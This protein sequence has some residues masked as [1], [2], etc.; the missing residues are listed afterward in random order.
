MFPYLL[1]FFGLTLN[2]R[3]HLFSQ[4]HEIVFHGGGGYDWDTIYNMPLWLRKFTFE[5][6]KEHFEKQQEEID[7][8][9]KKLT[10]KTAGKTEIQGP[11]VKPISTPPTY[12]T[13]LNKTANT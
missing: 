2:Y 9:E 4:I 3:V 11:P 8:Q 12:S 6:I 1:T 7:K 10:N 13:K 5:K